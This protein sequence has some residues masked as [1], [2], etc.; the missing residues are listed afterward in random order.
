MASGAPR[1][2]L[3]FPGAGSSSPQ[4]PE[5]TAS[6][7]SGT[8]C[9]VR[10]RTAGWRDRQGST[11]TIDRGLHGRPTSIHRRGKGLST[12]LTRAPRALM[13]AV[14]AIFTMSLLAPL[15]AFASTDLEI[16]DK[17]VISN[18]NGSGA[19][20]RSDVSTLDDVNVIL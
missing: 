1:P 3:F 16:G 8:T 2:H 5:G 20:L 9:S 7:V 12:L 10:I 4:V 18:P 19:N 15:A 13:F 11:P 6:D 14:A 17:A